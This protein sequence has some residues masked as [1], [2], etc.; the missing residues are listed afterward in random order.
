MN[1][2][3]C[4]L[5]PVATA[6]SA[7]VVVLAGCA[8]PV[9]AT[10]SATGHVRATSS[11]AAP[12]RATNLAAG[13]SAP[14]P[15]S[16]ASSVKSRPASSQPARSKRTSALTAAPAQL[17]A[18][19][20]ESWV[21]QAPGPVMTVS[22]HEIHLNE[23]AS[24]DGATTWQQQG[25]KSSGG[26]SAILETYTFASRTAAR[27]AYTNVLVGMNQCQST[28]R[29]LQTANH[30]AANAA[31]LGTAHTAIS[32]AFER[33]WTG[34]QGISAA[35]PQINHFYIAMKRTTVLVLHFDELNTSAGSARTYSVR[36]DPAVLTMLTN[37][38]TAHA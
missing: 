3:S 10:S 21:A 30:I 15:A 4:Y 14:K 34:V 35:G 26:D 13:P 24:V 33:T 28:S 18:F 27:A 16:A 1:L 12:V 37:L 19:K 7:T 36:N 2:K 9:Q 32:G 11:A 22:G 17:P 25:Y 29:R 8:G 6:I 23:C 31:C 20:A 38:L 5:I